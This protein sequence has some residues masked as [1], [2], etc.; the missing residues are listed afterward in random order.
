MLGK[1]L[2]DPDPLRSDHQKVVHLVL[3]VLEHE[4]KAL[5]F[6]CYIA[7]PDAVKQDHSTMRVVVVEGNI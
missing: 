2:S 5:L 1:V 4:Q 7:S 3:V 6:G